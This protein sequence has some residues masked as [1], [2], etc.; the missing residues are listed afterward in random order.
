MKAVSRPCTSQRATCVS[1]ALRRLKSRSGS[2]LRSTAI[3]SGALWSGG[4]SERLVLVVLLSRLLCLVCAV[5]YQSRHLPI[6]HHHVERLSCA[7]PLSIASSHAISRPVSQWRERKFRPWVLREARVSRNNYGLC[8]GIS[9]LR[10]LKTWESI[11][12][13]LKARRLRPLA[14][15]I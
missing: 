13:Q 6:S 14:N 3:R 11:L 2:G 10:Q 12:R 15:D 4:A 5:C 8:T 7:P 1:T 9:I